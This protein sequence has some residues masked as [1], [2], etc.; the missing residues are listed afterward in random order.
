MYMLGVVPSSLTPGGFVQVLQL[1]TSSLLGTP[2]QMSAAAWI[3]RCPVTQQLTWWGNGSF[4]S[5][6]CLLLDLSNFRQRCCWLCHHSYI[7][8]SYFSL[9]GA[10][11]NCLHSNTC[12]VRTSLL[13][14]SDARDVIQTCTAHIQQTIAIRYSSVLQGQSCQ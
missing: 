14:V 4:I 6:L 2:I 11:S 1:F 3:R 8:T 10:H 5:K 7:C 12:R 9:G 13:C